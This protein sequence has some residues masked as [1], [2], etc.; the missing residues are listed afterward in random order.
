MTKTPRKP[1]GRFEERGVLRVGI[2]KQYHRYIKQTL[3]DQSGGV[4]I[5]Y[6]TRSSY[7]ILIP[8]NID[9]IMSNK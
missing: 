4:I 5:S 3:Y 7:P 8:K 1:R 9:H 2:G 6:N